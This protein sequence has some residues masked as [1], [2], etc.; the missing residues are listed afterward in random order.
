MQFNPACLSGNGPPSNST[1]VSCG[2]NGQ[3]SEFLNNLP[4]Y[5]DASSTNGWN[6]SIINSLPLYGIY[7]P[8]NLVNV[9]QD[10]SQQGQ[11]ANANKKKTSAPKRTP[12]TTVKGDDLSPKTEDKNQGLDEEQKQ[13]RQRRLLKNR[14]AAQQF[15]QRQKEY[16]Q[17]LE[18]KVGELTSLVGES[19]KHIELLNTENR[20]LRDQLVYL[21]NVMRQNLSLTTSPTTSPPFPNNIQPTNLISS[22]I[23]PAPNP[24]GI[25]D[26]GMLGF[27]GFGTDMTTTSFEEM[28]KNNPNPAPLQLLVPPPLTPLT[29]PGPSPSPSPSITPSPMV[30]PMISPRIPDMG[31]LSLAKGMEIDGI[32]CDGMNNPMLMARFGGFVKTN[33]G[34][35]APGD[36]NNEPQTVPELIIKAEGG[37]GNM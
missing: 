1:N 24:A 6:N 26:L 25:I 36:H 27:K 8:S 12:P 21:Y 20:L 17:N 14:E 11:D 33:T 32:V 16:I 3:A 4:T 9:P 31:N 30:S 2:T 13:K 22:P 34:G 37:G 28:L 23:P 10:A 19:H 18:R 15:R 35:M 7:N 5:T 29:S